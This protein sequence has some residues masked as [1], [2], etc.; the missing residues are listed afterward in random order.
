MKA[1]PRCLLFVP[2]LLLGAVHLAVIAYRLRLFGYALRA[3]G[4]LIMAVT[5]V[6]VGTG[7][8]SEAGLLVPILA[9]AGAYWLGVAM[10][11]TLEAE[12]YRRLR[13][14]PR[15]KYFFCHVDGVTP[16]PAQFSFWR[17]LF[18]GLAMSCGGVIWAAFSPDRHQPG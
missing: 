7:L 1:D 18:P 16:A 8:S 14:L 13:K 4:A 3:A 2:L 6:F 10:N 15:S 12:A 17:M 11:A 5:G 9:G